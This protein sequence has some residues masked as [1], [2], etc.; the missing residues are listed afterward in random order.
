MAEYRDGLRAY[1]Q[2]SEVRLSTMHRI[3]GAFLSGAGLLLLFPALLNNLF[4]QIVEVLPHVRLSEE[5]IYLIIGILILM[6]LPFRAFYL[7]IRDIVLFYFISNPPSVPQSS[8]YSRFVLSGISYSDDES[9]D[10]KDAITK[11]MSSAEMRK[12]LVPVRGQ[13]EANLKSI[14]RRSPEFIEGYKAAIWNK[15]ANSQLSGATEIEL[16]ERKRLAAGLRLA[17]SEDRTLVEEAAKMELSLARHALHLRHLVLRYIKAFILFIYSTTFALILTQ[18]KPIGAMLE[19]DQVLV[20]AVTLWGWALLCPFFV[21][22][23]IKWIAAKVSDGEA[24]QDRELMRFEVEVLFWTVIVY[25]L[26]TLQITEAAKN[27]PHIRLMVI[28]A[29]VLEVLN[30]WY[31]VIKDRGIAFSF[32]SWDRK[33][34]NVERS[35][36]GAVRRHMVEHAVRALEVLFLIILILG[37]LAIMPGYIKSWLGDMHPALLGVFSLIIPGLVIFTLPRLRESVLEFAAAVLKK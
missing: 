23:P 18:A 10:V 2:R 6:Y 19:K 14:L 34:A 28:L 17:G 15:D 33:R 1:L 24:I 11:S 7:L 8:N 9:K 32:K 20:I 36:E 22:R 26:T 3:G 21:T 35:D 16:T 29:I 13:E 4:G 12:F 31:F 25:F 27:L 30:M 37:C 5:Y